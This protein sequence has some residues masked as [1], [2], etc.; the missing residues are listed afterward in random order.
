MKHVVIYPGTFNPIHQGHLIIANMLLNMAG[1]DEVWMLLSPDS[2][3]K[4]RTKKVSEKERLLML[5][6]SL[7][8]STHIKPSAI[9]L[10]LPKPSYTINTVAFLKEKYP[11]IHFSL[12]IGEDNVSKFNTWK[13]SAS[14][15]EFFKHVYVY[16]REGASSMHHTDSD[17]KFTYL[18]LPKVE[19]SST[20]IRTMLK[21]GKS[22]DFLVPDAV[23]TYIKTN[24]LYC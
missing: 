12:L 18:T 9:E 15:Y 1:I 10:S 4:I 8:A 5:T 23:H 22:I 6:L 16:P 7:K 24:K 2:P 13:S 21:Q 3:H 20:Q 17:N 19:L 14:L 11:D